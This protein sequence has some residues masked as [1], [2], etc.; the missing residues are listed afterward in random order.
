MRELPEDKIDE[1]QTALESI[2]PRQSF[3]IF[4]TIV[5]ATSWCWSSI[6][7]VLWRIETSIVEVGNYPL[8][9]NDDLFANYVAPR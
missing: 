3:H 2:Y 4:D 9:V 7:T 8:T 5:A 6:K 1:S